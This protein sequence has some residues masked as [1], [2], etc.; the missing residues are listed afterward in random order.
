M[1]AFPLALLLAACT[2]D[3]TDTD[4]VEGT[5]DVGSDDACDVVDCE[6]PA[7]ASEP[8]CS[9]PDAMTQDSDLVFTGREIECTLGPLPVAFDVPDCATRFT[10]AM[11]QRTAGNVCDG[12]DA[13]YEGSIAYSEDTC[14]D[15][16]GT[17]APSSGEWGFVA[18]SATER[19]LWLFEGGQWMLSDTLTEQDGSYTVSVTEAVN[20]DPP[21]C[22]N[23]VQYVGDLTVDVAFTDTP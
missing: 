20:Q 8:E 16:I 6:D 13:T 21:D 12:C 7:C 1:R 23:G 15:L 9:F 19:E 17:P 22:N 10:V 5:D 11:T 2:P 18:V 14:S 4:T 3:A